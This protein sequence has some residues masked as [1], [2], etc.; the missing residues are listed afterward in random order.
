MEQAV[1]PGARNTIARVLFQGIAHDYGRWSRVLSMGQDPR[2]R[3]RL[4]AGLGLP[5]CA[6]VLDVAAGTGE[7]SRLLARRNYR[8]VSLDL[9][10]E[11]LSRAA[12]RGAAAVLAR[13]EALPVP[14]ACFDGLTFGYLLRYVDD[15]AACL[16]EL[17]RAVRPG[18]VAAMLEFGRPRGLLGPLWVLYTRL[19]LRWAG[20]LI[21]PGWRRVGRFLGPD[22]EE[23]HRRL[24]E[25]ELL[26]AFSAAG[27][28]P[29]RVERPSGGGG[30]LVWGRKT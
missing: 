11:M 3:A 17:A 26:G 5:A 1:L 24:P 20:A 27:L 16:A 8:V 19:G 18:G 12:A 2:W 10:P 9:S 25:R 13:A 23:F 30:L 21:G 6:R 15:P 4:V 7:I 22:I 29:F 28:R 14:D